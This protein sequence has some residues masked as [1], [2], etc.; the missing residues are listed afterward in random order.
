MINNSRAEMEATSGRDCTM[1]DII[2]E[3]A[4]GLLQEEFDLNMK[5]Y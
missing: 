3:I 1:D 5:Q 4:N 2:E